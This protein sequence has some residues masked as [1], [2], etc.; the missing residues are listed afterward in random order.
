M[1]YQVGYFL[2]ATESVYEVIRAALPAD[3]KLVTL[4]TRDRAEELERVRGLDFLI[5]VRA[6]AETIG[7]ASRLRLLQLPGVGHDQVDLDAARRAGIPVALSLGGSSE[8]VA[9]HALMLMLA[10]GRRL[11]ELAQSLRAGKWWMWE[12]RTLCHGMFG[13]TLGI[14]GL[15]RIGR[16]VAA[17]AAAFGMSVQYY[18]AIRVDGY[19][20]AELNDLL[21]TSDLVTIHCPLTDVTRGLLNRERIGLMKPGAI[22][23][24]TARGELVNEAAL[25]EALLS[26]R[27]AGAGLDVFEKEP[28]DPASPL[29]HMDQV[30]ATPHVATGTLDS[31]QVKAAYYV[32]NIGRV[33]AGQAPIGLLT[34]T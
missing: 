19:R 9:E 5:S 6:S 32:E 14:I 33:L 17:R 11:V 30:I 10:V 16:E 1:G 26:G 13:K 3:M 7:A 4:A 20:F 12:R 23:I 18:D 28:P 2:P 22:L 24:N 31:L 29:L 34:E 21:R 25:L 8:A 27:L 15:G